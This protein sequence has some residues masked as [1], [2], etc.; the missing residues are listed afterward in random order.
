MKARDN[1]MPLCN[2]GN[3]LLRIVFE[4]KEFVTV[5]FVAAGAELVLD[6]FPRREE[7]GALVAVLPDGAPALEHRTRGRGADF[8]GGGETVLKD[9]ADH[10]G[11][12]V[13]IE[14]VKLR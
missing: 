2:V 8:V 3:K 14:R 11:V 9:A 12:R 1:V 4:K 10:E 6:A 7:G 5:F 13:G